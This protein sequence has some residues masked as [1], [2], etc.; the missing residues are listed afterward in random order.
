[1][2]TA[3]SKLR[4]SELKGIAKN[5]GLS[6]AGVREDIADRI[7]FEYANVLNLLH[8]AKNG[9]SDPDLR[10]LVRE[11]SPRAGTRHSTESSRMYNLSSANEDGDTSGTANSRSLRSSPKK[12]TTVAPRSASSDS[13]SAE[14]PLSEHQV[15]NF[16]ENVHTELQ[17]VAEKVQIGSQKIRRASVDLGSTLSDVISGAVGSK[18]SGRSS[19]E[20]DLGE[21]ARRRRHG[22]NEGEGWCDRLCTELK[23]HLWRSSGGEC[24]LNSCIAEQWRKVQETGSTS[25]GFVWITFV[26][27]F[28]VFMSA[29]CSHYKQANG[30]DASCFGFLTNW[31][32]FL[33]PFFSYYGSLFIIPTLLSQLFNV[34]MTRKIRTGTEGRQVVT[35]ILSKTTTSG[36]S[37]FVFKFAIT[38]LLG[39]YVDLHH[40]HELSKTNQLT[41]LAK[42]AIEAVGFGGDAD[43][44]HFLSEVFRFVPAALSLS[45]SG[46]GAVLALAETVVSR[47]R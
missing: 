26:F 33:L 20:S 40:Q 31:P 42:G 9:T 29:A 24:N 8:V 25:T 1:M 43:D 36:L 30:E 46:A 41:E 10:D 17:D 5:L 15:R 28:I 11:E 14:D 38:Y 37:Y 13:D 7:R 19:Q 16:M 3:L 34:D 39:Y 21:G 18:S 35:G 4:K 44:C 6:E 45:T 47:R 12:K 2:T 22:H 27:E 32:N 23:Y